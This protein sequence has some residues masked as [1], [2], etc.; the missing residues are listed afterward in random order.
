MNSNIK[1]KKFY[2]EHTENRCRVFCSM[3][4]K[5]AYSTKE[6]K[7]LNNKECV[8]HENHDNLQCL[9]SSCING[10]SK[11]NLSICYTKDNRSLKEY[12]RPLLFFPYYMGRYNQKK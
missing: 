12:R 10:F 5:I 2:Y 6:N 1:T 4:K 9:N 8:G 11:N 3:C 7:Y